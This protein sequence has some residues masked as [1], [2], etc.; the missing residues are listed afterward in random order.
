MHNYY[1]LSTKIFSRFDSL[2][3]KHIFSEKHNMV[4]STTC[5]AYCSFDMHT[6]DV[7]SS[8]DQI[9][10]KIPVFNTCDENKLKNSFFLFCDIV[11]AHL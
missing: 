9:A 1:H 3:F 4:F 7:T 11:E 6:I 10:S 2:G 8:C 5:F